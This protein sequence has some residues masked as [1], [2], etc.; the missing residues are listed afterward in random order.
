[1]LLKMAR[2]YVLM[3]DYNYCH[4]YR[5]DGFGRVFSVKSKICI[6]QYAITTSLGYRILY[7]YLSELISLMYGSLSTF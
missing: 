7:M 4:Y 2:R 1:M 3:N 5:D 6:V